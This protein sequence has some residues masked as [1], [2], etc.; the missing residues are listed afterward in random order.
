MELSGTTAIVS[1]GASGLIGTFNLMRQPAVAE[2]IGA[3]FARTDVPDEQGG[4]PLR[5]AQRSG[6]FRRVVPP[7]PPSAAGASGGSSPQAGTAHPVSGG[8]SP[9]VSATT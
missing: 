9:W 5:A 6:G 2:D 7:G 3:R 4:R 8:S 1:G